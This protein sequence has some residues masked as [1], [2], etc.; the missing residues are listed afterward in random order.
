MS[1]KKPDK[2]GEVTAKELAEMGFCEKRIQL[3]HLYGEQVTRGQQKDRAR[4]QVAHQRYLEE[5]MSSRGDRRCF[6]STCVFGQ[7]AP[8]TLVL[9]QYRNA[10]LLHSWCGRWIVALYYRIAPSMCAYLACSPAAIEVTRKV[11]RMVVTGCLRSL[12]RRDGR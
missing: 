1:R 9:R 4:G 10:V 2:R 11:L 12:A 8:E 3:A 7:D 5:G 6:V